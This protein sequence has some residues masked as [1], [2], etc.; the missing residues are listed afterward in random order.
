[1]ENKSFK[2][3]LRM[4]SDACADVFYNGSKA[5]EDTVI[6]CATKI[7]IAQ[8]RDDEADEPKECES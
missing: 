6:T 2:E 1:M 7:Y 4:V 3:I 5:H 8:M